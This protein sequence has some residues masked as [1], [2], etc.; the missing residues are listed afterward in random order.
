MQ[1]PR[2]VSFRDYDSAAKKW[3]DGIG[4]FH[5]WGAGILEPNDGPPVQFTIAIVEDAEGKI[6]EVAPSKLIFLPDTSVATD[7]HQMD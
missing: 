7:T 1:Q 2:K 6:W 4:L 3:I 5:Q